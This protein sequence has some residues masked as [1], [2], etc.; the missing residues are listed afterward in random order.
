MS[1]TGRGRPIAASA[2]TSASA[3]PVIPGE[4]HV[5]DETIEAFLLP[6]LQE[7]F[8]ARERPRREVG[9]LQ[10][11]GHGRANTRVVV[12]HRD[13]GARSLLK[14]GTEIGRRWLCYFSVR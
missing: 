4:F 5:G 12:D 2:C 7:F 10:Q 1:T 3:T 11:I 6:S 13:P 14:N 9:R 8:G